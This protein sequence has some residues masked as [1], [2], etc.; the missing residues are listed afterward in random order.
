MKKIFAPLCA[1]LL[2]FAVSLWAAD[3]WTIKPYTDWNEKEL[4]KI[5]TNSPWAKQIS[6]AM[7]AGSSGTDS[8]RKSK[9]GGDSGGGS[10]GFGAIG[11]TSGNSEITGTDAG[12]GAGF[13]FT[14]R[15]QSALPIKQALVKE[16]YGAEASKSEEAQRILQA[17]E[18]VYVVVITGLSRG[19]MRGDAD[20]IK[21][22]MMENTS[23]L[24]KGREP[25][26]PADF[27]IAG[28]GRVDAV[29][30]FPKTNPITEDDK[31]VEVWCKVAGFNLKQKFH[32][33]DMMF[34]GKLEL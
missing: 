29:F 23:L 7:P 18:P 16:K 21:K 26:K 19:M 10:G 12:G 34:D 28:Q 9:R 15:W 25:I 24:I 5:V 8:G 6:I 4:Q 30:A 27:R 3:F 31:D 13:S 11:Q 22:E 2:M 32:L 1:F 20:Q 17:S 14:V 33:K